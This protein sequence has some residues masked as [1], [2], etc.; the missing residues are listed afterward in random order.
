MTFLRWLK[1]ALGFSQTDTA[2]SSSVKD[3]EEIMQAV[4]SGILE[5]VESVSEKQHSLAAHSMEKSGKMMTVDQAKK[6]WI[7]WNKSQVGYK[8]NP[9]GSNKYAAGDWDVRLY[10]FEGD[11]VPWCDIFS[12][13]SYI[14]CFGFEAAAKMTYQQPKGFAACALSAEAYKKNGAFYTTPEVGDQIFFNYG[15][16]INH[17]GNVISVDG[18][19]IECVEGNFSNGVSLTKYN[20][21][22]QWIISGYGRPDWS[23]VATE[24]EEVIS[25][26]VFENSEEIG[27]VHPEHRRSYIHLEYGD[28]VQ[29]NGYIPIPQVKAWQNLL[30]C[31]GLDLGACGADGEFGLDTENATRQWQ[32]QAQAM[33]ADVEVNGIVDQDD[34]IEIINVPG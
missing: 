32:K 4:E 25:E 24:M 10:G 8:E 20:L 16:G 18:N 7:E 6:K 28:G 11:N 12:D 34:W 26:E 1:T 33:G 2:K 3:A 19:T 17:I 30:L 13:Y 15:D 14:A 22:N 5:S 29:S 23:I 27:I 31:W 21:R 9:D